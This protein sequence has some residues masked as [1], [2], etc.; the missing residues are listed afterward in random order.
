MSG[1]GRMSGLCP[2][3]SVAGEK[4]FFARNG[5]VYGN[6]EELAQGLARMDIA[7]F[8]HHVTMD[9]NDFAAWLRDCFSETALASAIGASK[10]PHSMVLKLQRRVG[11]R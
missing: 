10:S 4:R 8:T 9:R 11:F 5:D 6:L 7:T 1:G 2:L 3:R